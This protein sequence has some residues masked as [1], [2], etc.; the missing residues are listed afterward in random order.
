M[1]ENA[2]EETNENEPTKLPSGVELL[3]VVKSMQTTALQQRAALGGLTFS[4]AARDDSEL[5][6]Q[7]RDAEVTADNHIAALEHIIG[8]VQR[9]LNEER[10]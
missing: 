2:N 1:S 6:E 9:K 10:S 4:G 7:L 5:Y 8:C 3:R